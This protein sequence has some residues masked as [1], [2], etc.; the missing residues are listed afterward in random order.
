[1]DDGGG[2][3]A[4][5]GAHVGGPQLSVLG[6]IKEYKVAVAGDGQGCG[7]R[8]CHRHVGVGHPHGR[9]LRYVA[10]PYGDV[11]VAGAGGGGVTLGRGVEAQGE[12]VALGDNLLRPRQRCG[13]VDG[14]DGGA[15]QDLAE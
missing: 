7:G 11:V 5:S 6:L 2:G 14:V 8:V 1:M 3:G 15:E 4:G 9:L 10:V 12:L 13:G